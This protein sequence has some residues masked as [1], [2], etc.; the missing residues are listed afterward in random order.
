MA[1]T[2]GRPSI[3]W[4]ESGEGDPL[5]LVMGQAF[6]SR[7]WYRVVPALSEHYR[8]ISFDNRGIGR[9]GVSREP[10]TIGDLASDALSVLDAAGVE[11]AHVYGVSMG[12]LVAQELALSSPDRVTSLILGCTG[13]PDGSHA[14][15]TRR[16]VLR[17]AIP[18]RLALRL[19][20]QA[21]TTA[22]YGVNPPRDAVRE[23][24]KIL[25][26][27]PAPARVIEQQAHAIAGFESASRVGSLRLPTLVL[28]GTADRVV[29]FARGE[30]L[31]A[32][33]PGAELVVL[34]DAGHNYMT[35]AG[36]D[37]NAAVLRFLSHADEEGPRVPA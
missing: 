4:Q 21:V 25:A 13:A 31:A 27:T 26:S 19:A 28:H 15:A 35:D 11:R 6:G 32:L 17:R 14:A 23:D 9:S 33:I 8:V 10:F 3:W 34:P 12:G 18:R 36:D 37:A 1:W 24:L 20:G 5:L 7:M 16:S 2:T 22:M 29:P 30:E